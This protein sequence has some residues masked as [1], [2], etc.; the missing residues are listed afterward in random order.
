[1]YDFG[2][3][4]GAAADGVGPASAQVGP[5]LSA[6]VGVKEQDT[7]VP[8]APGVQEPENAGGAAVTEKVVL[9]VPGLPARS[10]LETVNVWLPL[11]SRRHRSRRFR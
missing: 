4:H 1:M 2:D 9:A 10:V 3:V 5:T 6:L 11:T 8:S 7:E